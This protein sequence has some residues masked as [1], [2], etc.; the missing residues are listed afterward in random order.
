[1]RRARFADIRPDEPIQPNDLIEG[2]GLPG[3]LAPGH[4]LRRSRCLL[5]ASLIGGRE[6]R[7]YT[8]VVF[9]GHNCICG[10]I[11]TISYALCADHGTDPGT[12]LPTLALE[13][14]RRHHGDPS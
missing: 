12:V 3:I 7:I 1:M 5:C 14:W 4:P 9:N 2:V 10:S 13:R 11:P 6:M 8:I